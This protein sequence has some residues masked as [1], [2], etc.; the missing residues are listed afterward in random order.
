MRL[1][2]LT[3]PSPAENLA[4][5]EALLNAAEV[6]GPYG[7]VLRLWESP[8]HGVVLGRN[9]KLNDEVNV[10]ACADLGVPVLRRSSGG[11]TVLIGPGC[12]MYSLVLSLQN[13][14]HLRAV[15]QAHEFVLGTLAAAL[16][17]LAPGITRRG[18]SDLA[19]DERKVS[20]NSARYRRD[21]LLYHG[22]LLYDFDLSLIAACL[23]TPPRQPDYRQ[24]RT[25][26]EFVMNLGIAAA[27]LK[28]LLSSAFDAS[29]PLVDWPR[30]AVERQVE[31]RYGRREWSERGVRV[32]G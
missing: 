6:G 1:L 19:V 24:R 22:T 4:L 28:D 17:P 15:D 12:L 25:H 23:N 11:A 20:G 3:L 27:S 2:D 18:T 21:H 8:V 29:E 30:A 10:A 5:D 26:A 13:R 31:E 7:E 32:L 16:A 9:S 14:P